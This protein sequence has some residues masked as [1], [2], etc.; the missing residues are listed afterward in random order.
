MRSP[1]YLK[2]ITLYRIYY[3]VFF[4]ANETKCVFSIGYPQEQQKK[5]V[6]ERYTGITMLLMISSITPL[7]DSQSGENMITFLYMLKG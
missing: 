4:S 1:F 2:T 6:T 3:N 5:D 7:K